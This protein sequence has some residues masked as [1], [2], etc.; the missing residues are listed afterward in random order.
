MAIMHEKLVRLLIQQPPTSTEEATT[1]LAKLK[2]TQFGLAPEDKSTSSQV[3][4]S[5]DNIK[6]SLLICAI[7]DPGTNKD[8]YKKTQAQNLIIY[9]LR[10]Y[11]ALLN[12][13]LCFVGKTEMEVPTIPLTQNG[14]HLER[15]G[16]LPP[17]LITCFPLT[18]INQT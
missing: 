6:I 3:A 12:C 10:R 15:N 16:F 2:A 7:M 9:H 1:S 8:E 18:A 13:S 4:E 14:I 17:R 5:D 11:A